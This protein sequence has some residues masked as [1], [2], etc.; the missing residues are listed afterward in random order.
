ME[1]SNEGQEAN[2]ISLE[3]FHKLG[4]NGTPYD[5][6]DDKIADHIINSLDIIIVANKPY[7]YEAGVFV[8]DESGNK[9]RAFIRSL[10][11][12]EVITINRINRVYNLIMAMYE[13]GVDVE[14]TNRYPSSW[15]N[16]K[17]GML[18]VKT[19]EMHKH[20]PKYLSINQIPHDYI[21]DLNIEESAFNR[22][23]RSRI[24]DTE[25]RQMLYEYMGYCMTK[26]IT[27]QKFMILHGLGESGKST[28]INFLISI[29]GS[30]NMC[31]IP[32]QQL[33]DRF[34]T[35]SLLFKVLNTCGDLSSTALTDT[36]AIKQLTG[37]DPIKGEY[38]GGS[39]FFFKNH[40]KMIFSCNE[41]PKVLDEKSNG[42]YRRI[43]LVKFAEAG[44]YIAGLREKLTDESEIERVISWCVSAFKNALNRGSLFESRGSFSGV[45][46]MRYE[47][48]TVEA[49]LK[50]KTITKIEARVTRSDLHSYYVSY[51]NEEGRTPLGKQGFNKSL[52]VKGYVDKKVNG[53]YFYEGIEV[54]F[55]KLR[56][57]M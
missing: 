40:A 26:D 13:L 38:K 44:E 28:I 12:Q 4:K 8:I 34:T 18:D 20:E 29:V 31:S 43:M 50:E 24:V 36:S 32:L 52:R 2:L 45:S 11:L 49:F 1:G 17:N 41:L 47:S 14:N 25:D 51:C 54:G 39:I 3:D 6:I 56:E 57:D 55:E 7:V 23:I 9:L 5:I 53:I 48:D 15:I 22:F 10:M 19:G 35:A 46:T 27:F 30:E 37:D 21:P 16:F 33:N 42:F